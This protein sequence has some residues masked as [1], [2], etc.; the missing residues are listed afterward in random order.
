MD[1]N[2]GDFSMN[3]FELCEM[4]TTLLSEVGVSTSF[5]E[6]FIL[7]VFTACDMTHLVTIVNGSVFIPDQ[8]LR[9]ARNTMLEL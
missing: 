6:R 5:Y 7:P 3:D 2:N 9:E 1:V 8:N 4:Y